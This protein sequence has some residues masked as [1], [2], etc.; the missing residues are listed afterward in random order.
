MSYVA[1]IK[2]I[3]F[4]LIVFFLASA[5]TSFSQT[6]CSSGNWA[7]ATVI[8]ANQYPYLSPGTG[9]TVNAVL[10][11]GVTTLNN[12]SYTCSG[13]TYNCTNPAWWLNAAGQ[14]ITLNFSAPVSSFSVI[15]NG[16]NNCEQFYF[17]VGPGQPNCLQVSAL[18]TANWSSINGGTGLL[19]TGGPAT[20]NLIVVNNPPGATQYVLT[21]N[22]CGAGSRYAVVDCWVPAGPAAVLNIGM[23]HTDATCGACDGTATASPSGTPGPFTYSWAP[24]GGTAA[25]ASNLC[26]GTYTVT[27]SAN[28]GCLTNSATVTILGN[29]STA[30]VNPNQTNVSCNGGSDGTATANPSGGTGPYTYSWAPSGGT[31][32]TASG[33]TAGTYTVTVT[34]VGA[35]G[36]TVTATYTLT[37]PTAVVANIVG[38]TPASCN[39]ASD[40]TATASGSGGTGG[41]NFS[42]SPSGGNAAT[43]TPVPAGAYVVTVT[44]ANGCTAT[45][46]A[47]IAEPTAVTVN[48]TTTDDMLCDG[49][50]TDL[51]ATPNGGAGGYSY[52]WSNSLAANPNHNVTPTTT[53]TYSVVVTDANGCTASA[54]L[55]INVSPLPNMSFN[56]TSV[57]FGSATD[58]TSTSNV[59]SGTIN[60]Y[61]WNYGD[62]SPAGSSSVASHNYGAAG[63]YNV[64]LTGTTDMGCTSST[65][66]PVDVLETPNVNFSVDDPYG[67]VTHCVNFTDNTTVN[68]ATITNWSWFSNGTSL[69]NA[70]S[71]SHCFNNQGQY[72]I[73]LVATSSDGCVDTLTMVNYIE[74]YPLPVADFY[75]TD[76]SVPVTESSVEPHDESINAYTWHWDMGDGSTYNQQSFVHTYLDLGTYCIV[77][78][79]TTINGCV[80]TMM[81]CLVVEAVPTLF[82]PDAF[83]P[84]GD[85]I[86]ELFMAKGIYIE[87]F[88]MMI[89]DRWGEEVFA[90]SSIEKGWDGS[91]P[92][93]SLA[94]QG[95]YV[96]RVKAKGTNGDEY[97]MMGRV[98]LVR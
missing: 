98:S 4:L 84:N 36:C 74:V 39:G 66:V 41:F 77:L 12:F 2:K 87:E 60:T 21:H 58:F 65:T 59:S 61:S 19:Y 20:S 16:T 29:V 80:D 35:G 28:G 95:V 30:V 96:Y 38:T 22:G 68:G 54:S 40:G 51:T 83:T 63:T 93:G 11:G 27:V 57:C 64:T 10:G 24:S 43:T 8:A 49:D 15:V 31:G 78:E 23:N 71:P 89:F 7:A 42:W 85:G 45:T 91:L 52:A 75:L 86:N 81:Q 37:E 90:F 47:N 25:T 73:S 18:C 55:P 56:A 46:T 1:F 3:K 82:I 67:C 50:M 53:T 76:Y 13:I 9:I 26:P 69:S 94:P 17:A 34:D 79:V 70:P 32:A 88:Q 44:D 5:N 48:L 33:L 14:S 6:A 92:G 72:T 97:D 62:G